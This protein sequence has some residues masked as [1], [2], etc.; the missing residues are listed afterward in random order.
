MNERMPY[1]DAPLLA[2]SEHFLWNLAASPQRMPSKGA[3]YPRGTYEGLRRL[4][5]R[6]V[7]EGP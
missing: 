1:V 4:S 2:P 5:K 7:G 6:K 3:A